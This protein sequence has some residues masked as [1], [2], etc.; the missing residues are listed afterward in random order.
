ML[1]RFIALDH[2][3]FSELHYDLNYYFDLVFFLEIYI[4]GN[5]YFGMVKNPQE[6]E[7]L[8]YKYVIFHCQ[9]TNARES[10]TICVYIKMAKI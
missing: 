2:I 8:R 9:R 1:K 10:S 6:Q 7:T 3:H 4:I 5:S